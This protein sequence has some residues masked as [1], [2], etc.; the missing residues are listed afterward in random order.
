MSWNKSDNE[1]RTDDDQLFIKKMSALKFPDELRLC[2]D[3][4]YKV[5]II[6]FFDSQYNRDWSSWS[7]IYDMIPHEDWARWYNLNNDL[8]WRIRF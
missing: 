6:A 4:K 8:V 5:P 2:L 7:L 3:S 1:Y